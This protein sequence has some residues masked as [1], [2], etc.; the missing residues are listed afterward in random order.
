LITF[1]FCEKEG[2]LGITGLEVL[3]VSTDGVTGLDAREEVSNKS[4]ISDVLVLMSEM[5]NSSHFFF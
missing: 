2:V 3:G 1:A 4:I 5:M